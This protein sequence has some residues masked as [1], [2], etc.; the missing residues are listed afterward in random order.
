MSTQPPPT[1]HL[2]NELT[3]HLEQV[4]AR[5]DE[6]VAGHETGRVIRARLREVAE[7]A[8]QAI[9]AQV[10]DDMAASAHAQE[11]YEKEAEK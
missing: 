5:R 4:E 9:E 2:I 8:Q 3:D 1:A 11:V 10:A 6:W 7:L